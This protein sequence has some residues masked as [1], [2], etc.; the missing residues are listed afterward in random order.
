M[1]K[2]SVYAF[3]SLSEKGFREAADEYK[4]RLGA[5]FREVELKDCRTPQN[6]SETEIAKALSEE[7]D[8]LIPLL[9]KKAYLVAMCV[10]GKQVSSPELS[11]LFDKAAN[12]G[13]S[14]ICFIIGSSYGLADKV[15]A[16][17]DFRLSL[18]KLTMP[19]QLARVVLFEAIYRS[20][21]ILK[22]SKYHK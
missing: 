6:P 1:I 21:E 22:G 7:A 20:S 9:P 17:A 3:G 11:E 10:E 14:E 13:Y 5:N 18:S 8:R 15:K 4:R 16:M 19:H 2:V 12:N